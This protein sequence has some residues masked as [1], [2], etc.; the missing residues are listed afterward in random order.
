MR[1][2][3]RRVKFIRKFAFTLV[4]LLVVIAIIGVLIALLLPAVQAA[5]E[6]ARRMSCTNNLK[7]W[8]IALHNYHDTMT[9]FPNLGYASANTF[10]VQAQLLPFTEQVSLHSLI[11][12]NLQPTDS[13]LYPVVQTKLPF[14]LCPSEATKDLIYCKVL[15]T[16][17]LVAPNSYV[18]CT[19]PIY[20]AAAQISN[21]EAGV[22]ISSLITRGLFHFWSKGGTGMA[23]TTNAESNIYNF[24]SITDG[25][26]NTMAMSES[27]VGPGGTAS[28]L[29]ADVTG[30]SYSNGVSSGQYRTLM[31][32]GN[33]A[34]FASTT[35][36][37][38]AS[39]MSATTSW[40]S[41]RCATWMIG[42]LQY[43]SYGAFL[44]PNTKV[45][46]AW[47]NMNCGFLA[48][49]SYHTG[50]VNVLLC[51]GSVRRISDT[52]QPNSWK[53]LSTI[54]NGEIVTLP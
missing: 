19:G 48:A 49:R 50:G 46:S 10:S 9:C 34:M 37:D 45:P 43:V 42:R 54:S 5:R 24:A 32:A 15:G 21:P 28:T 20:A 44:P 39:A 30:L 53:A 31:L 26:S 3:Y 33:T 35:P 40:Y 27:I 4:E 18:V 6:A 41:D 52:I 23:G 29:T 2:N 51:D 1:S 22:A 47:Y 38:L 11:N 7:Q 13:S 25:T 14:C 8:G 16:K 17:S 12:Y 36:E